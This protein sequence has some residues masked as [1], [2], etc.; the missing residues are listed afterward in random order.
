MRPPG[1]P[2]RPLDQSLSAAFLSKQPFYRFTARKQSPWATTPA[3]STQERFSMKS[4]LTAATMTVLLSVLGTGVALAE[5][6]AEK[7]VRQDGRDV[8]KDARHDR[9]EV[10]KGAAHAADEADRTDTHLDKE[11]HRED[12]KADKE[13][14]KTL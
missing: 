7:S 14:K 6:P 13:Y 3:V 12:K 10:D 11:R 4:R 8:S 5:S 2:A 1:P 9:K